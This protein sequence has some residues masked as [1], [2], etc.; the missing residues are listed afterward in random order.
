M[1]RAWTE[2]D[3]L[4]HSLDLVGDLVDVDATVV[5]LLLVV[6]VSALCKRVRGLLQLR[7]PLT[8]VRTNLDTDKGTNSSWVSP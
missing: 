2:Q 8:P 1:K 5:C 4:F 3:T 7:E 6:T